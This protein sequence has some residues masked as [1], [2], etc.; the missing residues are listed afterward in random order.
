MKISLLLIAALFSC[1]ATAADDPAEA[2]WKAKVGP[3]QIT[4][5]AFAY[6]K[7]DP[8][9]PR[10][11]LIGDSISIGYTPAVREL[12]KGK[13]NVL[14]IPTNGSST[15]E[16]VAKID[17]WL[18]AG[19]WA[20]IHFN[21]GLHDLKH[22]KD[23]K[24][25]AAGPQVSTLEVYEKNLRQL[26]QRMKQTKAKLI[27]GSTTPVPEGSAGRAPGEEKKYN[28][29]AAKVMKDE[30]V[31][32]NDLAAAVGPKLSELQRPANVHFA[33]AGDRVL[34]ERVAGAIEK[35]LQK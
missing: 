10:V 21:W 17:E 29:V 22:W 8:S 30:G 34:G 18:G 23:G 16:G 20:V 1:S 2:A 31:A 24:L 3:R 13:A 33:P 11:L 7:E 12:L 32:I 9:L 4:N 15:N 19:P 28:A 26:V 5:P 6:V 27:W 14:R 35:A 25:D